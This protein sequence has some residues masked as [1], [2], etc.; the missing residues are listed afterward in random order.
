MF[1]Y[2]C[3]YVLVG[4]IYIGVGVKYIVIVVFI[5]CY[6]KFMFN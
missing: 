1:W 2:L 6:G 5:I 4:F 3:D